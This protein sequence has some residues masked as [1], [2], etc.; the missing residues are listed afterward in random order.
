MTR[1]VCPS[2]R[3]RCPTPALCAATHCTGNRTIGPIAEDDL[4][5]DDLYHLRLAEQR[6]AQLAALKGDRP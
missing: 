3:L 1:D 4:S 6:A 5:R 2:T